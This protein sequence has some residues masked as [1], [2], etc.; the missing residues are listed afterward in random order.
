M[1][2]STSEAFRHNRESYESLYRGEPAFP[3]APAPDGIS[4]DIRQAQ[5]WLME[6]EALGAISG[7]VLDAGCGLGDNAIYLACRGYTVTGN[8]S[9]PTA[10]EQARARAADADV[11]VRFDVADATE[12]T[13]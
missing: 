9:S 12:L 4:W 1:S 5:P 8:D 13:G 2:R 11:Q 6:L 7:E 10:I 3:G